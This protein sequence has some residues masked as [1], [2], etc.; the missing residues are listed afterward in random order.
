[1]QLTFADLADLSGSASEDAQVRSLSAEARQWHAKSNQAMAQGAYN[2]ALRIW[3]QG[4]SEPSLTGELEY[5]RQIISG[6]QSANAD[7]QAGL[8]LVAA[9]KINSRPQDDS[10]FAQFSTQPD[11]SKG[12]F[13]EGLDEGV[14]NVKR[15]NWFFGTNPVAAASSGLGI[16]P[17]TAKVGLVIFGIA[18][19]GY[20]LSQG[21]KILGY[22]KRGG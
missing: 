11:G 7:Y 4:G 10:F 14:A 19:A 16:S 15:G 13:W 1:M 17:S 5:T 6:D 2:Q 9:G 12:G 3:Q 20:T 22:F 21:S 8:A 18:V